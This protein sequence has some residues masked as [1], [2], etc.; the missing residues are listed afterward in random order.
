VKS[1][2]DQLELKIDILVRG[3][4]DALLSEHLTDYAR[5]C[6]AAALYN[7][8]EIHNPGIPPR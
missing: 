4:K 3:I 8:G 7:A 5:S 1:Q 2:A 6:L